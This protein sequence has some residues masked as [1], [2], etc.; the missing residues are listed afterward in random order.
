M[1]MRNALVRWSL[2]HQLL[3]MA[4]SPEAVRSV[5]KALLNSRGDDKALDEQQLHQSRKGQSEIRTERVAMSELS[6][7]AIFSRK[8]VN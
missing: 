3:G 6:R 2:M 7:I 4:S 5:V 1:L 8:A